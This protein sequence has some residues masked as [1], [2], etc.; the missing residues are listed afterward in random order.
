MVRNR[1]CADM[2]ET[3]CRREVPPHL[4]LLEHVRVRRA[5]AQRLGAL[6]LGARPSDF[7]PFG[8]GFTNGWRRFVV[9][10]GHWIA[11]WL[12]ASGKLLQVEPVLMGTIRSRT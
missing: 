12:D 5:D 3:R 6:G 7:T 9:L 1:I 4:H 11:F 8:P 2:R 10:F